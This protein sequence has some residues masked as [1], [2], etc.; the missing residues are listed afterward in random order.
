MWPPAVRENQG[1]LDH[2]THYF[3]DPIITTALYDIIIIII[4]VLLSIHIHTQSSYTHIMA[5]Y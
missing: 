5:T 3:I 1:I 2:E 4:T